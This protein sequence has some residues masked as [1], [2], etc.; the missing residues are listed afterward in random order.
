MTYGVTG[1]T[2][3]LGALVVE[4]LLRFDVAPGDIMAMARSPEKGKPLADLGVDVRIA[5]YDD[6]GSLATAFAG[7]DRLLLVSSSEIGHRVVQHTNVANAAAQNGIRLL[8]YTSITRADA[9]DSPLA[10]EHK[11]TEAAIRASGLPF[12]FLRNNWYTE[13][14]VDTVGRARAMGFIQ[15][16]AGD[17]RVASAT[18]SDLAEAAARVLTGEGHEGSIYELAGKP[19][20]YNHLAAVVSELV[21]R[22]I[23]Y[24]SVS[25]EEHT[26]T[27]LGTGM[28][29]E[30]AGFVVGLDLAI[31]DGMLD[32]ES[33]DLARLL[34]RAPATLKEGLAAAVESIT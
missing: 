6:P 17:G 13:N 21:G 22:E 5:E 25:A 10:P 33:D 15:A 30:V 28:P 3:K 34:G 26:K 29:E 12:V 8:A 14:Y 11:A 4:H 31:A 9:S 2:G 1:S 20:D 18:R 27:L 32:I 16:A 19:W 24:R 23:A 7:V